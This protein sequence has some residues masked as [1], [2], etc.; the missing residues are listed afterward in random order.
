M[1]ARG[2]AYALLFAAALSA[3]VRAQASAELDAGLQRLLAISGG[4]SATDVYANT[5]AVASCG[6]VSGVTIRLPPLPFPGFPYN[7]PVPAT[8]AALANLSWAGGI[9]FL[10]QNTAPFSRWR[11]IPT[12]TRRRC[13][14]TCGMRMCGT[15]EHLISS[16]APC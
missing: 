14:S 10:S 2:A 4:F 11:R 9:S 12:G 3:S 13:Q 1:A 7:K 15:R 5:A 8:P 6:T 16:A